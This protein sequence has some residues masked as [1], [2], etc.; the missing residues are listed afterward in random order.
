MGINVIMAK[1]WISLL[2]T[3]TTAI[4]TTSNN[5]IKTI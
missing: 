5:N 2:L 1:E 4:T 3:N